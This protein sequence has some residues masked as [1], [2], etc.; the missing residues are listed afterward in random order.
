MKNMPFSHTSTSR[1]QRLTAAL[2]AVS[3]LFALVL[4]S[5]CRQ[6]ESVVA[7]ASSPATT[8]TPTGAVAAATPAVTASAGTPV[9]V[10]PSGPSPVAPADQQGQS[11]KQ[12][13]QA[14]QPGTKPTP[15]P[16]KPRITPEMSM[17]GS[18]PEKVKEF[19][20]NFKPTPT[21]PPAPTPK[22]EVV[23]GKIKQEWEAP[24]EFAKLQNPVAKDPN[25][26]KRGREFYNER[27]EICHG[28]LG[29][30]DG[31]WARNFSKVP[32]NLASKV[33]QANTDGEL[34]YKVTN[35]K[36]P[37]PAS[38]VRFTDEER[39]CIV[40]FIRTMK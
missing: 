15:D 20:K 9:P 33:V 26:V 11:G 29:R 12:Q 14:G 38:K 25:A 31:A 27:C 4:L 35:A 13:E 30:G 6:Q 23:N 2:L 16:S 22:V 17:H 40:S 19:M 34:F 5:A 18:D 8:S 1:V 7:Q 10:G 36:M 21:P 28:K 39:W 32:T 3:A 24:A 37:H